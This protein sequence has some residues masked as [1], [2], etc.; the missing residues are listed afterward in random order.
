[1]ENLTNFIKN[2]NIQYLNEKIQNLENSVESLK[3][4]NVQLK[5]EIN[6]KNLI[7]KNLSKLNINKSKGKKKQKNEVAGNDNKNP[8]INPI[9][10]ITEKN[11]LN[12][13]DIQKIK[14]IS[15]DPDAF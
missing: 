12:D 13:I 2:N 8:N 3:L 6:K 10:I 1:M 11:N 14:Q 15:I 7:F 9:N 4:E 5:K